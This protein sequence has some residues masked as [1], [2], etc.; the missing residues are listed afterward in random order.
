MFAFVLFA[1]AMYAK[2]K[3]WSKR[4]AIAEA[5]NTTLG[6]TRSGF[7]GMVAMLRR[8]LAFPLSTRTSLIDTRTLT[9]ASVA[10]W[11]IA[12]CANDSANTQRHTT[13]SCCPMFSET[14]SLPCDTWAGYFE[15]SHNV[16]NVTKVKSEGLRR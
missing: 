14:V 13:N 4:E 9:A 8:R 12:H 16:K 1:S 10:S 11:T 5:R 3:E 6:C 15:G 7:T 2:P